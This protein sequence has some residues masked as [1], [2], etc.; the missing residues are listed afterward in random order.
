MVGGTIGLDSQFNQLNLNGSV[1]A[2][3]PYYIG[4][5]SNP[6]DMSNQF[7]Q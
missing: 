6:M 2:T 1:G 5:N 7:I 4:A 3:A